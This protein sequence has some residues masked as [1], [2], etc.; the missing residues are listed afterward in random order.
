MGLGNP[1]S[2][3]E[4]GVTQCLECLDFAIMAVILLL[5]LLPADKRAS[6]PKI[7]VIRTI[8]YGMFFVNGDP[9]RR[10][11]TQ[12]RSI[13]S[14]LFLS[15]PK[16]L[17]N[18]WLLE[19]N[20]GKNLAF[21]SYENTG[22]TNEV[23]TA[24]G[25][26]GVILNLMDKDF[27]QM[28][29]D[30]L[31]ELD[32]E[33]RKGHFCL[34]N[35]DLEGIKEKDLMVTMAEAMHQQMNL[36]H[37][38]GGSRWSRRLW[39]GG[40]DF[41]VE[42]VNYALMAISSSSSSSSSD[43]EKKHNKAK[44]EIRGYEIALESLESRILVHEKNELAW[45]E[46]Y[47]FQ[48]YELKCREIKL[49]TLYLGIE[50]L[51][52]ERDE[53]KDKIAK[54]GNHETSVENSLS[55]FDGLEQVMK[56]N[57]P[58]NDRF[59]KNGYK[60]VPP[61][62]TGNFLTPRADISFAVSESVVSNPK[63]NR[64][65]V[66]IEDWNSDDEEEEY[67]VQTVRPETQTVKT[68]D[69]KS[70]QI[71]KK[72]GIGFRKGNPEILLQDHAVV[73]LLLSHYEWQQKTYLSDY[74]DSHM[75]G[76]VA[77]GSDPKGETFV[78]SGGLYL[79]YAN[80][81]QM[82]LNYGTR[83][84]RCDNGT[85]FKN[86]VMNEFYAKKGIKREFSVARTPQQNGV[87]E[88]KNVTLIEAAR[89]MLADSLL[90]SILG[91]RLVITECYVLNR[92][93]V[94]KPQN[95][96]PYE[97]L[98][99]KSPSISF[100]RPFGCPLTIL[101]TLNSLGKFDGKSDEGCLLEYSTS[102]TGPNWM[103]DLDFLTNSMNYI[104]VNVENQVNVDAGTQDSYIA[105]S[106]G[107][108]K[109][110]TQEYILLPLQPHRTRIPVEDVPPAAH[111]KPSES[112][113][114]ENDVQDS[115]DAANKEES[116]YNTKLVLVDRPSVST[117]RPSVSTDRP[118]VS[119][120]RP[121]VLVPDRTVAAPIE[122]N[123]PLVNDEDGILQSH[124][125]RPPHLNGSLVKWIF[126]LYEEAMIDMRFVNVT[127]IHTDSN[128]ADLL[129]KGFDVT[130][131]NLFGRQANMVAFMKKPYESVGFTEVV[132]VFLK[133]HLSG[134]AMDQGDGSA[135]PAEPHHTPVDP[136]PS[137]SLPPIPSSPLQSP[138][139]SPLSLTHHFTTLIT[140]ITHLLITHHLVYEAHIPRKILEKEFKD[141]KQTLGNAVLKLV[142]K[143]KSRI[144]VQKAAQFYTE[145]D[146][147]TIRAKLEANT[148][149][150]KS[151]QGESISNDDFAKRMVEMINEKKKFYAEQ[152][153]KAK[154]NEVVK[155][156]EAEVPVKKTRKRRKQ[157][158]RKGINIA[159]TAQDEVY[160]KGTAFGKD[161]VKD[162]SSESEDWSR[163]YIQL[164]LSLP[165]ML[166]WK[167][168]FNQSKG[169]LMAHKKRC[170]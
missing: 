128:V 12:R 168:I 152:K 2:N 140:T 30:V 156:E 108:D 116:S 7:P 135:Q 67:E 120:D 95:K 96:T 46:K 159:K 89:T 123:K 125:K 25:D 143:V 138:P 1:N 3:E 9:S 167:I 129:T 13:W 115:E 43:S 48:N 21:L 34:E 169:Q 57:T 154:R 146:W 151:L 76:F 150:V 112:S 83:K 75:N 10:P 17:P 15:T 66:I 38:I 87:A 64:D 55:I 14:F 136:L 119:T 63:I 60:D 85:E 5:L 8:T 59:S 98:I 145:E 44:L 82:S 23:S 4:D 84:F 170:I 139:H 121:F 124:S 6:P 52:R 26:F 86:H 153:A 61:P 165:T 92:V 56:E 19:G 99:G 103:F 134:A 69:D 149:V 144:E 70:G 77:F 74:E 39:T 101:N 45:G 127:K 90:L 126:R 32:F 73:D 80:A 29:G 37:S 51:L 33:G 109:G 147:D 24:S 36:H 155:E 100:M 148:E 40:N 28:D 132:V 79:L 72:H 131:F 93:L 68:R 137:T 27:Q 130:R 62:I 49:T 41:E 164:I 35:V 142:K 88:R 18:N 58:E 118:S 54:M 105:G 117:D 102:R 42:P 122:S 161:K 50:K 114:K 65:R 141:T 160:N 11:C 22:S 106:S 107:K 47:E 20:K 94:T 31:E 110:P 104:P 162:V 53:F 157:K 166:K 113:P 111:E 97:L 163:C 91:Q 133:G 71:S 78:P 158:E 16:G 81:T